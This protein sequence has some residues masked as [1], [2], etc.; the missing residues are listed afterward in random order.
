[1]TDVLLTKITQWPAGVLPV[2]R[3]ARSPQELVVGRAAWYSF[4]FF[5]RTAA[6]ALF[7]ADVNDL[8]AGVRTTLGPPGGNRVPGIFERPAGERSWLLH[9]AQPR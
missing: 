6:S 5:L 8:E 1:V 3:E 7:D 2:P 9:V 4:A